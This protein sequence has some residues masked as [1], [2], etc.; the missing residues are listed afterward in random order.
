[1][2]DYNPVV[3]VYHHR[4]AEADGGASF[5]YLMRQWEGFWRS[6]TVLAVIVMAVEMHGAVDVDI[7]V[8]VD[9]DVYID[10]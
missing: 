2:I 7:D 3:K 8:D 6:I 5:R 1:M 10:T 4:T 9:V